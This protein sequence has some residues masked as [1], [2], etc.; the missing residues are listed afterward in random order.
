M[1]D[2]RK[3]EQVGFSLKQFALLF[4]AKALYQRGSYEDE[5]WGMHA[6]PAQ[7]SLPFN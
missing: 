3:L 7:V 6:I 2:V 5:E 4:R 1:T